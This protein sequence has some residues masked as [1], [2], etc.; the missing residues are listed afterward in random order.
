MSFLIYLVRRL[1][2]TIP[3]LFGVTLISFLLTYILPGNPALVKAGALA[4]PEYIAVV[5]KQMGLDQPV[6]VQYGRYVSGLA[7]GDLGES[8]ATGR[9]VREDFRQ[10]LPAT[11]ELTLASLI[12]A[13]LIGLPLGIASAVHRDSA[14]D[15]IGRI[16]SV[17]GVAMPSFW[18]GLLLIYFF[19]MCSTSPRRPLDDL[20]RVFLPRPVSP[21]CIRWTLCSLRIGRHFDRACSSSRCRRSPSAS[22]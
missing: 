20:R 16:A 22:V 7:R 19:F 18:T 6:W 9:P 13:T 3:A 14:I 17:T 12:L 1:L 4:T 10:R 8:S 15:H 2:L 11:L 21:V 5:E